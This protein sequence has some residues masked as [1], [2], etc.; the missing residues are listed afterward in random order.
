MPNT[1][2]FYCYCIV[3]EKHQKVCLGSEQQDRNAQ[4][5]ALWTLW[6]QQTK[7][8]DNSRHIWQEFAAFANKLAKKMLKG[9]Y[10]F[11]EYTQWTN[12]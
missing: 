4:D 8:A 3:V 7:Q 5:Q 9:T 2:V 6:S 12:T 10:K 11:V 1:A